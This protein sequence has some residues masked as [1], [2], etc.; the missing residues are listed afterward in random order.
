MTALPPVDIAEDSLL[1]DLREEWAGPPPPE[2][3]EK[4][5]PPAEGPR[6]YVGMILRAPELAKHAVRG[7]ELF[8]AR[9]SASGWKF[10]ASGA[11]ATVAVFALTLRMP[12]VDTRVQQV[13]TGYNAQHT[14]RHE[15]FILIGKGETAD[16]ASRVAGLL[17]GDAAIAI[18]TYRVDPPA[19]NQLRYFRPEDQVFAETTALKPTESGYMTSADQ[20][21]SPSSVQG[22]LELWLAKNAPKAAQGNASKQAR[23]S[24]KG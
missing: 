12:V 23:P 4:A 18:P 10:T 22:R 1:A 3:K 20:V 8:K 9:F 24:T 14:S 2:S 21:V 16:T 5:R 11:A 6:R 7:V 15:I 13:V 17:K 19:G